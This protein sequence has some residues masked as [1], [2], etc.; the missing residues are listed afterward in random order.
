[1]I[2][3]FMDINAIIIIEQYRFF[4]K[5]SHLAKKHILSLIMLYFAVCKAVYFGAAGTI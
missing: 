5:I 2:V 4:A 3:S 1:M